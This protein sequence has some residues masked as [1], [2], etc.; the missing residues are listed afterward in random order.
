MNYFDHNAKKLCF[1]AREPRREFNAHH[2]LRADIEARRHE[3]ERIVKRAAVNEMPFNVYSPKARHAFEF[4]AGY[5]GLSM[6]RK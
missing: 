3:A 2:M 1:T 6:V 5:R 4:R